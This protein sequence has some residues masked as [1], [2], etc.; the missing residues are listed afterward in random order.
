MSDAT[1]ETPAADNQRFAPL[2]E[3]PAPAATRGRP[4]R[5]NRVQVVD[6]AVAVA[7]ASGLDAV[8]MRSV[9][10]ALGVGTMTLYSH[11]PSREHLVDAMIDRAYADFDLPDPGLPWRPALEA[12]AR[13][14]WSL[15]RTHPWL[16]AVNTWRMPLAP[17]VFDAEE[18]GLRILVDTGLTAG[19]VVET[20]AI[21]N[22]AVSGFARAAAAEDADV[23]R[24]GTDYEA[25]WAS[26]TDFWQNT[27]EPS[28]YPTMTRLWTV[29]AF[30]NGA[31]P[32]EL[33]IG[34]LLDTI[35]LLIEKSGGSPIPSFDDCMAVPWPETETDCPA[36]PDPAD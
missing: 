21:V 18:S 1:P 9:A 13:G 35:E 17:N 2:W 32:F 3:D 24:Q 30:D 12:Y 27:F 10:R 15:L 16:L 25:Y 7:D 23:S 34:A 31:T 28:R 14:Y 26:Q 11:V 4:A 5:V 36:P 29:G 8:S 6:A 19:Q 22:Q 33:R 20:I